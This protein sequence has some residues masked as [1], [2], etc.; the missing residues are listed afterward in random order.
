[1]QHKQARGD[2]EVTEPGEPSSAGDV[3]PAGSA[4]G[5]NDAGLDQAM[6][7]WQVL[8]P[9]LEEGVPFLRAAREAGIPARTAQRWLARYRHGGLSALTRAERT[10]RGRRRL[11]PELVSL[12]EG[13][14]LTRPR[15]S[16]AT[17]TRKVEQVAPA[18]GWPV[19]SY[20]SVS[21]IVTGL[22]PHL[23]T[24]AH[25]GP[26][27]LRDQYELVYRRQAGH[28]NDLWQADH[29]QLDILVL[30]CDGQPRARPQR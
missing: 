22:D 1:L 26:A 14:A 8:R 27:A 30:D 11:P 28:P 6:A 21:A 23:M 10:D 4:A 18:H 20:S 12:I 13:L 2:Y 29:T 19:P 15:P 3:Q 17:I 5:L 16:A 25:E 24:L 9:H 7:R